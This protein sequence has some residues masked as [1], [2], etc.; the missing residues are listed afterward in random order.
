[1]VPPVLIPGAY[2]A[3]HVIDVALVYAVPVV[4]QAVILP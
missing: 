2:P 1:M 3:A 4:A